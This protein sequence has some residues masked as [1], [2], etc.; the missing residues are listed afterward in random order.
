MPPVQNW[1]AHT[2]AKKLSKNLGVEVSVGKVSF[3]FLDKMNMEKILI[4][5]KKKD[6]LLY[7]GLLNVRITDWFI[8]KDNAELKYIGLE[9]AV[10][11]LNRKDSVW[12]YQFMVDYFSS[13]SSPKNKKQSNFKL[14]LKKL[15]FKNISFINKD[16]WIGEIMAFK[17]SSLVVNAD[18]INLSNKIIR[19]NDINLVNPVF[20]LHDYDGLEP[21]ALLSN[22]I[23]SVSSINL[24]PGGLDVKILQ[25]NLANGSIIINSNPRK[26]LPYF[27]GGH[28]YITKLNAKFNNTQLIKDTL[29]SKIILSA[30]ERSGFEIKHLT[31]NYKLTPHLMEF[32]DL[33]A[34]TN[35]SKLGSYYA[36]KF[37]SF[38]Y[39]FNDYIN[40]VTMV[41]KLRNS[42]IH[43]DD[44]AFFAPELKLWNDELIVN[45]DFTGTVNNYN[46][47]NF[48]ARNNSSTSFVSCNFFMKGLPYINTTFINVNNATVKT[49]YNDVAAYVPS[50]TKVKM[51]NLPA[52]GNIFFKG[53]YAGTLLNFGAQGTV[54]TDLG[55]IA[56]NVNMQ[57]PQ[58][59]DISY[60]GTVTTDNFNIGKFIV[61]NQ[62]GCI[63]FTGKISGTNFELEKIKTTL[64]GNFSCLQ[65][66]NYNYSNIDVNGAIQKKY[67]N[68][69]VNA[70]DSNLD[71]KSHVEI[72]LSKDTPAFNILGDIHTLNLKQLN[73]YKSN[74]SL[75]ALVDMNFT[76]NNID[77]FSGFAKLLN[78]NIKNSKQSLLFDSLTV[79]SGME[80]NKK[81]L[82]ISG[83][84]FYSF[85]TGD[86]KILDLPNNFQFFL[87]KY[88][89]VYFS[90]PD[91][92]LTKQ[93]FTFKVSTNNIS[94]YLQMF[95]SSLSGFNYANLSGNVDT[96][97]NIFN[98]LLNLPE[99][100]YN[101]YAVRDAVING[102]GN[103]DTLKLN[104]NI[105][106]VQP[107]DSL[108]FP[109][110]QL[111]IISSN[112]YSNVSLKTSA[113]NT[114]NEADLNADVYMLSNKGLKI[115]FNPS[116][117]ILNDKQW[118]L[119]KQG[120]IL[121]TE[122]EVSA[123]NVK[124][125]QGFQEIVI[126][127]DKAETNLKNNL[128]V[129]LK[130]VVL[131]DITNL[132]FKDPKLEGLT[133]GEI[134]LHDF[135]GNFNVE[136]RLQAQQFRMNEDSIGEMNIN[137]N[138]N[139]ATGYVRFG[140]TSPNSLYNFNAEGYYNV[141]DSTFNPL[142][143]T[144]HL[145]HTRI[146]LLKNYL[147][148][149]FTYID[150]F[151][152]G[153]ITVKGDP[154]MP[155]IL[156]NVKLEKAKLQIDY[157]K[158]PYTIDSANISFQEN[159]ID[160]GNMKIKDTLLNTA[161]LSGK[162]YE[163]SFKNMRFDFNLSTNKLLLFNTKASDNPLF[164]GNA[165]G[166]ADLSLKGP[167]NNCKLSIAGRVN[168]SSHIYIPMS[169]SKEN[170][171]ADFIVF[172][173]YG[174][175]IQQDS[176]T[177]DNNS[178]NLS[179]DL[180]IQADNRTVIDVILDPLT[181]DI[182]RAAGNGRLKI[183][184]GTSEP[185]SMVGKYNIENGSYNFNFQSLIRKPF[186][187][188]PDAGNYIEWTGDPFN[189]NIHVEAQY[190]AEN[191]SMSDLVGNSFK[192][193]STSGNSVNL[194]RGPVY[195]I[196][197]LTDKLSKPTINFKF[198]FPQGSSLKSDPDFAQFINNIEHDNNEMLKQ[199]S[200]LL[201][202]NTFAPYG[203]NSSGNS[204]ALNIST[205]GTNTISQMVTKFMNATVAKALADAF[206]DKRLQFDFGASAYS[207]NNLISG[208]NGAAGTSN[209]ID[210]AR[211]N[212]KVGYKLFNDKVIVSFGGDLDVGA[213]NIPTQWL[214]D[215]TVEFILS[216]DNKLRGMVF[217]KNS[218]D[219]STAG[220]S[221]AFGKR[222]R[223]G[224][225][226]S[227][228]KDFNRLLGKNRLAGKKE[229]EI[230]VKSS[231][232]KE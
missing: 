65:F 62:L 170:G 80:D 134:H 79:L 184:A 108:N 215:L 155:D 105:S 191:V 36:M 156:G 42:E 2:A 107:S 34:Q 44:I 214:P 112:N 185:F 37:K 47:N 190:T 125:L 51:P 143:T 94:P 159:G 98:F 10:I 30:K 148:D 151:A 131:G 178:L 49:N 129:R 90:P 40:R 15:N 127:T 35:K 45:G 203:N 210:R 138:Y 93:D 6:T 146:N 182:L 147:S 232:E 96:K 83:N 219:Y 13:S 122:D 55:A 69:E 154:K 166:K 11:N 116:S 189:A 152:T 53:N 67:F 192:A 75:T 81:F 217:S 121:I 7:A 77:N 180:D 59:G 123:Q 179:V 208:L 126:E 177:G 140:V 176:L 115:H 222:T 168:D 23:D 175:E 164:Y 204:Y 139:Y 144:L 120:E 149:V 86:F 70:S 141:K 142:N 157:T 174:T 228:K 118:Q 84:E 21:Q 216:Q 124:F 92:A 181:G 66:N 128:I 56:A 187:L 206:H 4:R 19:I 32:A 212:L 132:F 73:F 8:F 106:S 211:F 27:D 100:Q 209:N 63:D 167:L 50:I 24:N 193:N 199:V 111:N 31:A 213:S 14:D 58:N 74:I 188:R 101:K 225:G 130:N 22:E 163:K 218:L 97:N 38:N 104:S 17:V 114:F 71:F 196:A 169:E 85:I 3:S 68:G 227:Y 48:L 223:Q 88:Y 99:A 136:A 39:D 89:P 161:T 153:D 9:D 200:Y 207:S 229:D 133:N 76:A 20:E 33:D 57:L 172:K 119:E 72:D 165:T 43:S 18:S 82:Q 60:N 226:L 195:V 91:T 103:A 202:F 137:G 173:Q 224:I 205:I 197:I 87:S 78:V 46:V 16:D 162:L 1:M 183:K 52:L 61:N 5:D 110:S 220:S 198:D 54:S 41:S 160:F 95:D 186:L 102:T 29:K 221:G 135:F 25:T 12:N 145:N 28:I 171:Q 158:V 109:N 26:P 113:N 231:P 150:G 230:E 194:Y 117:F 64:D 201:V